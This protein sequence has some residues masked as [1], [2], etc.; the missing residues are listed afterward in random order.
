[1]QMD[2]S[3]YLLVSYQGLHTLSGRFTP[4][5]IRLWPAALFRATCSCCSASSALRLS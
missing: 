5:S 4:P 2:T 3:Q 1:M